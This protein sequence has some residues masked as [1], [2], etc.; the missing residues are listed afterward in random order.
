M[1]SPTIPVPPSTNRFD[2]S[3]ATWDSD[4]AKVERARAVADAILRE[5][6]LDPSMRALEFGAGTGLLGFMLRPRIGELTLT[7]VSDGMLA[8]ATAK[9]DAS[10]DP[11]VRARKLDLV[12]DP[13]PAERWDLAFSLMTLH[14]VA[15]T[16]AILRRLHAV[17]SPSGTLCIADLDAEDGS[18]HG[19]GFDGHHG[20]DRGRLSA[21]ARAAGFRSVAFSTAFVMNK[22]RDGVE[23]SYPIFLMVATA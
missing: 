7:D 3:A 5:V 19:A 18:F 14:H 8:V 10:G 11:H 20:F 22:A 1:T 16:D 12:A 15:D 13:L 9:I 23:R 21:Q 6:K 17:L 4:P 2:A